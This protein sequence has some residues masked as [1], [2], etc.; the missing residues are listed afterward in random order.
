[1]FMDISSH[2]KIRKIKGNHVMFCVRA[3]QFAALPA[4]E[5][6][7]RTARAVWPKNCR[8]AAHRKSTPTRN[9]PVAA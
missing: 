2:S 6:P 5:R 3:P 8:L 4:S 1:M 9:R 7:A